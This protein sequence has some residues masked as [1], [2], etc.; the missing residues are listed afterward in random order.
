MAYFV[1]QAGGTAMKSELTIK[2]A[3]CKGCGICVAFCPKEVLAIDELGKVKVVQGDAC[4]ACGQCEMRCPE[5]WSHT[6]SAAEAA[7]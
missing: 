3:R 6:P 4:I 7:W 1:Y 5:E 2:M